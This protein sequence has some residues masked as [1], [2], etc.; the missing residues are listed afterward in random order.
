MKA[1]RNAWQLCRRSIAGAKVVA[2]GGRARASSSNDR[3]SPGRCY[4]SRDDKILGQFPN[5]V[6]ASLAST[7]A[8]LGALADSFLQSRTVSN[9]LLPPGG[10]AS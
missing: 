2:R 5:G 7:R 9:L 10:R 8:A 1:T 6:P 3:T 4:T